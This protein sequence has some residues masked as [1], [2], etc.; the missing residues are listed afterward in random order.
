MRYGSVFR[1]VGPVHCWRPRHRP[2]QPKS[3]DQL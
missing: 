1:R 2:H 3:A